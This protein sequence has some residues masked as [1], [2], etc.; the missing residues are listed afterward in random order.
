MRTNL[1]PKR[2]AASS[3][4]VPQPSPSN[5]ATG[6]LASFLIVALAALVAGRSATAG[7]LNVT[8]SKT[9]ACYKPDDLQSTLFPNEDIVAYDFKGADA[10]K[11][12]SVMD[13]VSKSGA[14]EAMLIRVVLVPA[15]DDAFAFQFGA[16]GC[17]MA[18]LGLDFGRMSSLFETAGVSPPFGP[19]FY[20]ITG[21][22]I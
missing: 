7:E 16:D 22:A 9:S 12:K 10:G 1:T 3:R 5:I 20:Q 11:L 15:T 19:T 8:S 21:R 17:S 18:T 14:A 4:V 6:V 2:T 13:G